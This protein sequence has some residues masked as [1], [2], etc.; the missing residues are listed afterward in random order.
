MAA[1]TRAHLS[2]KCGEPLALPEKYKDVIRQVE[3]IYKAAIQSEFVINQMETTFS[4]K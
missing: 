4:R 3:K 1:N 2:V